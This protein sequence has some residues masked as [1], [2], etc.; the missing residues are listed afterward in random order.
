MC[1]S[2]EIMAI[3]DGDDYLIGTQSFK[4]INARY[5]KQSLLVL[6]TNHLRVHE[7]IYLKVGTC[8]D[9][10]EKIKK[11][12]SFR[13]F[14]IF[15]AS[16]LR[17]FFVDLYWRISIRDLKDYQGAY[18]TAANDFAIMMPIL[19]MAGDR[20]EYFSELTYVYDAGTGF[21]N[22]QTKADKQA[23]NF[24]ITKRRHKYPKL[25]HDLEF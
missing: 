12:R 18:F 20:Y 16:H 8:I 7:P 10:P 21:N 19:E 11:T 15:P 25:D 23:K 6:Y 22:F 2:G 3:I 14:S 4:I 9:Y 17:T 5:Q 24:K 13:R 1:N